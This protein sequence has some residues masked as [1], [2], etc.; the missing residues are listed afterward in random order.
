MGVFYYEAI[1]KAVRIPIMIQDA[2][3]MTQGGD[4]A[5]LLARLARE[6]E[7][8]KYVKVEAPPTA[9]RFG[10]ASASDITVFGAS[11]DSS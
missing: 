5:A 8:V 3:L 1:S 4:A 7:N 9:P 6:I 10:R 11:T 2:P